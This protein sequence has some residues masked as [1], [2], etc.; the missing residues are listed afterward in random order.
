MVASWTSREI[1][2][3]QTSLFRLVDHLFYG[4]RL[5]KDSQVSPIEKN[6]LHRRV[7]KACMR[8]SD[9]QNVDFFQMEGNT[10]NREHLGERKGLNPGVSKQRKG[11]D[12]NLWSFLSKKRS[13][14]QQQKT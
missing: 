9:G 10:E 8:D 11:T 4:R 5:S 6:T 1:S 7:P 12:K 3:N 13:G 2:W 14:N